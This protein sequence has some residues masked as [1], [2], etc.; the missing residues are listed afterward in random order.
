MNVQYCYIG[1]SEAS[2][3]LRGE[4]TDAMTRF[5]IGTDELQSSISDINAFSPDRLILFEGDFPDMLFYR[6]D[7]AMHYEDFPDPK[8]SN[9]PMCHAGKYILSAAV[10]L[11]DQPIEPD[12][13]DIVKELSDLEWLY[14]YSPDEPFV[15]GEPE[16]IDPAHEELIKRLTKEWIKDNSTI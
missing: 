9:Y 13:P 16:H 7:D 3:I 15:P 10:G 5:D 6:L 8:F 14:K 2:N 1:F 11:Q 12:L 4:I